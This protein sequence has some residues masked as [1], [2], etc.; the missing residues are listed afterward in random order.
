M[1]EPLDRGGTS[2]ATPDLLVVP[3]LMERARPRSAYDPRCRTPTLG[4]GAERALS[5]ACVLMSESMTMPS[6]LCHPP[7]SPAPPPSPRI[8][9]DESGRRRRVSVCHSE[10]EETAPHHRLPS[11]VTFYSS[12]KGILTLR[13]FSHC[14]LAHV[15]LSV[16]LHCSVA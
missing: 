11:L 12:Q 6:V 7:T 1:T 3:N 2:A 8:G 4:V 16:L 15:C 10:T 5:P 13:I 14:S 9:T